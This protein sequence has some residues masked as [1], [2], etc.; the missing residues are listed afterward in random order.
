MALLA[1]PVDFTGPVSLAFQGN[2]QCSR[3]QVACTCA[4][5]VGRRSSSAASVT[6][7]IDTAATAP[8]MHAATACAKPGNAISVP[9]A[10]ALHMP[11]APGAIGSGGNS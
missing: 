8:L 3:L 4:P 10:D 2:R 1:R 7:A 11:H 9:A 6:V 5:V